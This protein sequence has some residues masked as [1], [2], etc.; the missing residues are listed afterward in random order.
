M[1]EVT[2]AADDTRVLH[3]RSRLLSAILVAGTTAFVAVLILSTG[4]LSPAWLL[5]LIP[6]ILASLLAEVPGGIMAAA[7]A[8]ASIVLVAPRDA[9]A[10]QWP[11]LATGLTIFV[12]CGIVVGV[13]AKRRRAHTQALEAVSTRDTLTG[14]RKPESFHA[15]MGEEMRRS[16]R[17]GTDVGLV[18][19]RVKDMDTFAR[20]F[21]R[22]KADLMLVH[23][24]DVMRLSVRDTDIVGRIG[25]ETFAVTI[26]HGDAESTRRVADRIAQT[27]REAQFEGDALEPVTTCDVAVASG[28]Y[29]ADAGDTETLLGMVIG[30]LNG[31]GPDR[32]EA[33]RDP[34][35]EVTS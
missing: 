5:Y 3:R 17:Y 22:Y 8:A 33:D 20:T 16:D 34:S 32:R 21:G 7:F 24:A 31:D 19:A 6:V 26:P 23:L 10:A 13:Q 15:R 12:L 35:D 1:R 27:S 29:P 30:R 25:P 18:V 4:N 28:S 14:V 11:E 2:A 9:L